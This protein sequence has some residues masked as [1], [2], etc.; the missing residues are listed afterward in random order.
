MKK[1]F[2]GYKFS[3]EEVKLRNKYIRKICA[4]EHVSYVRI[5]LLETF[6]VA[7]HTAVNS[8]KTIKQFKKFIEEK[9]YQE[10]LLIEPVF[11][12]LYRGKDDV[13]F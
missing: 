2:K 7:E 12:S 11:D 13:I 3:F 9:K 4:T 5:I 10:N 6:H 8:E 1:D